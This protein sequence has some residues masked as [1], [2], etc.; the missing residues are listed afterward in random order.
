MDEIFV[1]Y[2]SL[3][4]NVN[5]FTIKN[6]DNTYSIIL[7]SCSSKEKQYEA[8]LHELEH[9]REN[10]FFSE[11]EASSIENIVRK[12]ISPISYDNGL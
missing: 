4:A 10:D 11:L 3:P 5:G 1:H 12:K 2:L 7:N 6:Q 9:I 8:Y